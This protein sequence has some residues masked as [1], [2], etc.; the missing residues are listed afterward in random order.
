MFGLQLAVRSPRGEVWG[1]R[2][3]RS[4][5]SLSCSCLLR[6]SSTSVS[7][8]SLPAL[9]LRIRSADP[10]SLLPCSLLSCHKRGRESNRT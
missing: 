4:N 8:A 10:G 5:S 6:E 7:S 1:E 9:T 2:C 3:V